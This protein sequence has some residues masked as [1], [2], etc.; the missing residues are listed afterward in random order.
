[1]ARI[2]SNMVPLGSEARDFE[3]YDTVSK[4]TVCYNELKGSQGTIVL[5]ICNHCPYV[6]HI[7]P[8]LINISKK[9]KKL[10][11][12][13]IA[14]SSNDVDR[15]PQD[16]PLKMTKHAEDNKYDFP[17][18]FD[19]TQ[20]VAKIYDAACTPDIYLYN[21]NNILIYRGQIDD[22]RPGNNIILSGNDLTN[23]V[24]CLINKV[25]NKRIQKPSIGCNI[26]WKIN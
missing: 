3:L 2:N 12:N 1:M 10:G 5:F 18:L 7:N 6:V 11:V 13:I 4:T 8:I 17:Y 9:Y 25:E 22:S 21:N 15:Y 23:A 24:E 16:G 19:E 26:K 20:E 14:I